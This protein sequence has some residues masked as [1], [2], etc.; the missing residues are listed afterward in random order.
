MSEEPLLPSEAETRDSLSSELDRLDSAWKDYVERVRALADEWEKLKI[1]YL[2]KISRTES[3]L[4]ATNADLEKINI[5]LTLGL[6]SEDE[7]RDEKSRL[8]ERKAKL[9]ARLRALQE[10][11]ETIEDRLL[12]HL[13]R[14][15]ET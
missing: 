14:I 10:I 7:K 8:E 13:S 3:L 9:E 6:A 4:K 12:E 1:K 15:R 11:V 2:E 5:E